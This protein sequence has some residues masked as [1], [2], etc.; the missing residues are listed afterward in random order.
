MHPRGRHP[1]KPQER[2]EWGELERPHF[3]NADEVTEVIDHLKGNIIKTEALLNNAVKLHDK[4]AKDYDLLVKTGAQGVETLT[5]KIQEARDRKTVVLAKRKLKLEGVNGNLGFAAIESIHESLVEIFSLIPVNEER[6]YSQQTGETLQQALYS[7]AEDRKR[8]TADLARKGIAK[9]HM[10]SH[11][12]SGERICPKCKHQ[13]VEGY[14]PEMFDKLLEDIGAL[15]VELAKLDLLVRDKEE[16]LEQ[17]R[18]YGNYYRAFIQITRNWPVLKSFW[19]YLLENEYVVKNPRF[20]LSVMETFRH[21]LEH[22]IKAGKIADEITELM[23]MMVAAEQLG[24]TSLNKV[25]EQLD[26]TQSNIDEYTSVVVDLRTR[27]AEYTEYRGQVL[28]ALALDRKVKELRENAWKATQEMVEMMRRE[29]IQQCIRQLQAQ[30]YRKEDVL[31][32]IG[33]QRGIVEHLENDL[34]RL[35]KEEEVLKH[36]VREISPTEGIIAEGLLGFIRV[37]VSQM[38]SLIKKIWTYP[39]VVYPCGTGGQDS[40]ELDYYF[41]IMVQSKTGMRGDVSEGSTGI[42]EIIDVAFK[43]TAMEY[44]GMEDFPLMLDEF[45]TSLDEAHRKSSGVAIKQLME[46]KS[47]SQLFMV[48]HYH[49]QYGSLQN[50][51]VCVLCATNI[52]IPKSMVINKHV[53]IH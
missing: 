18:L 26:E 36:M 9:A 8:L 49:E 33:I 3:N 47:F 32:H 43:I 19:D 20:A 17:N 29:S 21:D 46:I 42:R 51:E 4:H 30:L 14:S 23:S 5:K 40:A 39:L 11:R 2:N 22:E 6:R 45:G 1:L 25:Q 10:E 24:D 13:W 53:E 31:T 50:P 15:E 37:F 38:N 16:D 34:V 41:P 12:A 7:H 52:T 44:L 28:E 27:L 35:E 48:S